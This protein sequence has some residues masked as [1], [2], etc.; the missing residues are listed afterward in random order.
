MQRHE[1]LRRMH[2]VYRPRTY[3][4]IGVNNGRSLALSRVPSVAVDPA[5]SVTSELR[6]DLHLVRATSDDFFAREEPFEHLGGRSVDLAFIDGMHLLEYALRDFMNVERHAAWSS[7][8]VLDDQLPR[9]VDEAARSRHTRDWAGDVYKLIP[10]LARHRPDLRLV[11]LDTEPTGVLAIFG[12]DPSSNALRDAYQ[13]ILSDFLV[14]DPQQIPDEILHRT[15][16][17]PP[18]RLLE[19]PFWTA[20]VAARD[21]DASAYDRERLM[22]DIDGLVPAGLSGLVGWQPDSSV[23]RV[24]EATAEWI[25]AAAARTQERNAATKQTAH[26][27]RPARRPDFLSR[28]AGALPVLRRIP[29]ARSSAALLRRL[30][31]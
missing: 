12:A 21:G 10:V 25:A 22:A 16:A 18:E 29:G 17:I 28:V 7:V 11:A 4:E 5:Y 9:N 15:V 24:P 1:F 30:R 19:A 14:D 2:R 23:A 20:L 3:F 31:A 26:V 27:E 13:R 8:I 6:S